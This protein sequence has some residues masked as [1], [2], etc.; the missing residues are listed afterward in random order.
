VSNKGIHSVGFA[1]K[2]LPVCPVSLA[3]SGLLLL[4]RP[5]L[6]TRLTLSPLG[7]LALARLLHGLVLVIDHACG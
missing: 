2:T 7:P 6:S 3:W 4:P 5:P 1:E